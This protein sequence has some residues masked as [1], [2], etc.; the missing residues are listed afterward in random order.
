MPGMRRREFVSAARRRG[1][2][3]A[4]RGARAAAGDAGDRVSLAGVA[5]ELSTRRRRIPPRPAAKPATSRAKTSRSSIA[6]RKDHTI[7]CP[8]WRPIWSAAGRCDRHAGSTL[9]ARGQGGDPDDSDR[10]QRR[11][12]PG[13]SSVSSP[14]STGRAA[15]SPASPL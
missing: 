13:R 15:T 8:N 11:R 1:G 10:V 3:V 12:R 9:G 6:G 2:G 7:D 4:A 5:C 14:A